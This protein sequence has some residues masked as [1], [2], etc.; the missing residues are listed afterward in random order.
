MEILEKFKH[1]T[2]LHVRYADLDTL[3]HVNN[4]AYLTYLE[5]ARICYYNDVIGL[6][7]SNL[8]FSSVVANINISYKY[9]LFFGDKLE[10]YTRCSKIGTKSF[11]LENLIFGTNKKGE[12]ILSA[13][14]LTT[15][16]SVDT[17]T[18]KTQNNDSE[19]MEKIRNF[20]TALI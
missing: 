8:D 13:T 5:E 3:G 2:P 7:L 1:K 9:P 18:G 15:M 4:K 20:E 12:R 10:V 16:V 14:A 11:E 17:K 6:D 19:K